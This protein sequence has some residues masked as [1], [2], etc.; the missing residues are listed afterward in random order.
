[1]M[2][3]KYKRSAKL[4]AI[5]SLVIISG[6]IQLRPISLYEGAETPPPKQKPESVSKIVSP[7]LFEDDTLNVWGIVSD[8]CKSFALVNDIKYKG[9]AGLKLKWNRQ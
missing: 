4:L 6:C 8:S 3:G 5:L 1:M 9:D 2:K 7:I